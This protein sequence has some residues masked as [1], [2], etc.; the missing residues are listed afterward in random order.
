M[1]KFSAPDSSSAA[2]RDAASSTTSTAPDSQA[3]AAAPSSAHAALNGRPS[4]FSTAKLQAVC[5]FI[6]IKGVSDTLAAALAGVGRSTLSRWKKG[7]EEV[8]MELEAARAR[9]LLPR[10]D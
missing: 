3:G 1:Y 4:S 6:H 10:L 5:H 7:N 2:P 8:E 9:Y